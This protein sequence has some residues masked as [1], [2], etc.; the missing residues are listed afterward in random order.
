MLLS[1]NLLIFGFGPQVRYE[2]RRKNVIY[3]NLY[4]LFNIA[5]MTILIFLGLSCAPYFITYK[6]AGLAEYSVFWKYLQTG[7]LYLFV[8]F[9]K[10]LILATFFP[11]FDDSKFDVLI[12]FLKTTVDL[13]D[14][15]G[16]YISMTKIAGKCEIKYLI[17]GV[18][19][20]SAELIMTKFFPL[21][22]GARGAEFDWKYIQLSLDSS[23]SLAH[24]ITTALLVYLYNRN[25]TSKFSKA[26]VFLIGL[27][28]YRPLLAEILIHGVGLGS[29]SLL[30]FKAS[31]TGITSLIGLRLFY[32]LNTH[33]VNY[34]N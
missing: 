17:A 9:C 4:T 11:A 10:M 6:Y 13:G 12:E 31:F 23:I 14:L 5:F 16:L 27:C 18:G 15:I 3:H 7:F 2:L 22:T 29:W 30:F 1:N 24:H 25:D 34:R 33:Y 21:W 32:G 20:A 28:C 26:I 19:W 8:Q